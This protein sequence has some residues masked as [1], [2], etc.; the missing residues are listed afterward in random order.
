MFAID[1]RSTFMPAAEVVG[2]I[3][4]SRFRVG[5][6]STSVCY[7]LSIV[8]EGLIPKHRAL[9]AMQCGS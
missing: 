7:M 8:V 5:I 2:D 6:F 3:K 9:M 4:G 1:T